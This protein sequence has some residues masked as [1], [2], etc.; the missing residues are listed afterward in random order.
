MQNQYTSDNLRQ[1]KDARGDSDVG[2]NIRQ[3]P[4]GMGDAE[5]GDDEVVSATPYVPFHEKAYSREAIN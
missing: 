5:R 1:W 3:G 4:S 2:G